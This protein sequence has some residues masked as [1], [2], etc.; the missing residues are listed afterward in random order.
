MIFL[1]CFLLR[2]GSFSHWRIWPTLWEF[3]AACVGINWQRKLVAERFSIGFVPCLVL[4]LILLQ[5]CSSH[6]PVSERMR[7]TELLPHL[8]YKVRFTHSTVS[9]SFSSFSWV[10]TWAALEK[11]STIINVTIIKSRTI[12]E[13]PSAGWG[14]W[15]PEGGEQTALFWAHIWHLSQELVNRINAEGQRECGSYLGSC[16]TEWMTCKWTGEGTCRQLTCPL[17][18]LGSSCRAFQSNDSISCHSEPLIQDRWG[19]DCCFFNIRHGEL[20]G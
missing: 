12:W 8:L 3:S 17:P 11:K 6:F 1:F 5:H 9:S 4:H 15:S 2:G 7:G 19:Q 10:T 18:G 20:T 16:M 14:Q 13:H